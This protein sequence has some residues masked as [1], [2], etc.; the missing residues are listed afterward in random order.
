MQNTPH[1]LKKHTIVWLHVCV[2]GGGDLG[3]VSALGP[4]KS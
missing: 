4:L 1:V 2:W 3:V